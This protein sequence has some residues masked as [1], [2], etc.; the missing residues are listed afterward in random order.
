MESVP[1][2]SEDAEVSAFFSSE[3]D[4]TVWPP[5]LEEAPEALPER[6]PAE[7]LSRRWEPVADKKPLP[8]KL[9]R[10][11]C[12]PL[13]PGE[14]PP[15]GGSG[16]RQS[17]ATKE[18]LDPRDKMAEDPSPP[19]R[20]ERVPSFAEAG[21]TAVRMLSGSPASIPLSE[22]RTLPSPPPDRWLLRSP[23]KYEG[24]EASGGSFS[25]SA[26]VDSSVAGV[27]QCANGSMDLAA[28]SH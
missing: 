4:L 18:V 1:P 16:G 15:L 11:D 8:A 6:S 20:E 5:I 9:V 23:P 3:A 19:P 21:V 22:S 14:G 28:P 13:L 25:A 12:I 7:V 26:V 2:R 27:S 10:V 17:S 24:R